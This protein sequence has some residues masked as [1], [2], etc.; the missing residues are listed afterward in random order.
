MAGR[1]LRTSLDDGAAEKIFVM[2]INGA[3]PEIFAYELGAMRDK[4]QWE[5][6]VPYR[7][8]IMDIFIASKGIDTLKVNVTRHHS[9]H[10]T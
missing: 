7:Q 9:F 6:I 4:P 1:A 3:T 5:K 10:Q 2:N 8:L